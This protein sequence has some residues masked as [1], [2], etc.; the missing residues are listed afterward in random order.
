MEHEGSLP[1]SQVPA[2][3]PYPEP[4]RSNP[5]HHFPTSWVSILILYSHLRPGLP[6]GL[7][8]SGFPTKTLHTPLHSPIRATWHAHL[9]LLAFITRTIFGEKYKSLS[10]SSCSF[11]HSP[12]TSYLAPYSQTPSVCVPPSMSATLF[13]THTKQHAK[14][15]AK[16]RFWLS[17]SL[18]FWAANWK[19][20]SNTLLSN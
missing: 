20:K 2:S 5:R 18:Y 19:T 10:S 16:L 12:V 3:C 15:H 8:P 9:I 1:H 4:D 7:F 17:E 6:S 13:H 11:L 14:Q